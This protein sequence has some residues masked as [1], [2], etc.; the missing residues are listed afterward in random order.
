MV[1]KA[2]PSS[3]K[4]PDSA[5][6]PTAAESS[7]SAAK[8]KTRPA[9]K[10]AGSRRRRRP[11]FGDNSAEE[12]E[13]YDDDYSGDYST[14]AALDDDNKK[15]KSKRARRPTTAAIESGLATVES[16]H[17]NEDDEDDPLCPLPGF[18]D[19]ISLEQVV[20]PAI[21][22]YGHVMGYDSWVRCLNNWEGK[23]N[24]CPL[25]KKPLSKRDLGKLPYFF[26]RNLRTLI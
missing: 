9:A 3:S 23:K 18:V 2:V 8:R 21:S 12:S 11:Q 5:A 14:R 16:W 26:L 24:T 6:T 13:L 25:T 10:P 1:E 22:K 19:P 20:K 17:T 15:R 4:A 7:T